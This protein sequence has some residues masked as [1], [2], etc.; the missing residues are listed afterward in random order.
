MLMHLESD[1]NGYANKPLVTAEIVTQ[2]AEA[3]GDRTAN[4]DKHTTN[5]P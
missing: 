2:C 5:Y 1:V 4:G 3:S